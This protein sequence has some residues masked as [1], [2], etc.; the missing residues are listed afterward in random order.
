MEALASGSF[1]PFRTPNGEADLLSEEAAALAADAPTTPFSID[2]GDL[3]SK[4]TFSMLN[5]V[6][7]LQAGELP[8]GGPI[9]TLPV[10][11]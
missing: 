11:Q 5:L 9:L 7:A 10:S 8:A 3:D 1:A 4:S 6:L 2:D